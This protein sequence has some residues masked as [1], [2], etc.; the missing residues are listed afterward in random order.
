MT[1][2]QSNCCGAGVVSDEG[3]DNLG[4]CLDCGEWCE[5]L[6]GNEDDE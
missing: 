2:K 6:E 5:V 1:D 3:A 4:Q